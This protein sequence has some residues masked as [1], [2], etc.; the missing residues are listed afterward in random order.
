M[1]ANKNI[2]ITAGPTHE[3]IDPVRYLTNR[4]SGRMGYAL[5]QVARQCGAKVTLISGPTQLTPAVDVD[6]I[7][8]QSAQ[9]MHDQVM[10]NLPGQHI[11]IGAAAV[12]DYRPI[13]TA[14]HKIKKQ[15]EHISLTLQRTPDII[16]AVAQQAVAF[17]V[18]FAA[19][20]DNVIAYA[21]SKLA[22]KKLDMIVA[23]DVSDSEIGFDSLDN[24]VTIIWP[25]GQQRYS[26]MSKLA[27]A[28]SI[29]KQV[30]I[31]YETKY[32]G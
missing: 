2:L 15:G 9:Q 26:R 7:A 20:T 18:G 6:T 30:K 3:A 8:V 21:E 1:L 31:Q 32:S 12:A 24:A 13:A 11:V 27:I 14:E 4:S 29:L 23:N 10:A 16:A 17:V 25:G 5:A 28:E 19:E 22:A